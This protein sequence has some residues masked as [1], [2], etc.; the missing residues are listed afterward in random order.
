MCNTFEVYFQIFK[1]FGYKKLKNSEGLEGVSFATFIALWFGAG[2][3]SQRICYL[4]G[5]LKME[6]SITK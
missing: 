5:D 3:V 6:T 4:C 1:T 2:M